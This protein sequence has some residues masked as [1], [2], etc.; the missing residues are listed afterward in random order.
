MKAELLQAL[1]DA[2][3]ISN[4]GRHPAWINAINAYNKQ[5]G[6]AKLKLGCTGCYKKTLAWLQQS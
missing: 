6:V 1:K 4:F 2:G 3:V 5:P